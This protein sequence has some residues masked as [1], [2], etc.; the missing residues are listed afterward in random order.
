R[1]PETTSLLRSI[2]NESLHLKTPRQQ[3]FRPTTLKEALSLKHQHPEALIICGATDVALR[4]TKKHEL[5]K[6]IIDLSA[7]EELKTVDDTPSTLSI[8]AGVPLTDAMPLLVKHFPAL[9]GMLTVFGSQQIRNLATFGGNLGTASPIGDTMPVLMA[10]NAKV[11]LQDVDGKREVSLDD[12]IVGYR[13]TVRKPDELITAVTI[14]KMVNGALVRSYKVSKRKD[15]DI[16]TVSAGF[17]LELNGGRTVESIKLAYGGMAETTRRASTAEQFLAGKRW[18]RRT[19]EEAMALIEKEF[20]PIS[21]AR[22]SAEFR[23]VAAKNLLLKFWS[24]TT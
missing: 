20:S 12:Y 1:E 11:V 2:P 23:T 9:H 7:I 21:D 6:E 19:V 5:L 18:E 15:L 10:Y 14:P 16:S 22:G 13:K 24:E 8:G 17:R 4:V 3:Y